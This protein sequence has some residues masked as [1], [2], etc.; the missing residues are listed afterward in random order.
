[1]DRRIKIVCV[2]VVMT[3]IL[4]P[5]PLLAGDRLDMY[6][7]LIGSSSEKRILQ[8]ARGCMITAF[9]RGQESPEGIEEIQGLAPTGLYISLMNGRKVRACM[10]SFTPVSYPLETAIR[11]LAREV[12]Y[13]DTRTRPLS[14]KE[15]ETLSIVISFV[16][17]LTAIEDP[18]AIDFTEQGLYIDQEGKGG[19]L[20]PGETRTL[21]YGI[22]QLTKKG[23]IDPS[24][25]CRFS[26]FKVVAFDERRY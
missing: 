12:I 9:E 1:M 21:D 16:G 2:M 15:M 5:K 23:N 19:V 26:T 24:K 4:L 22:K 13:G 11:E 3:T 17:S 20:L 10:G 6:R 7:A 8:F 18:Y 14:L 25:P